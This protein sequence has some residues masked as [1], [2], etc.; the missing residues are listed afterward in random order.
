MM[1]WRRP[2]DKP[3]FETMMVSLLKHTCVTHPQWAHEA[4]QD[5]VD[6][7]E[8]ANKFK[9][10]GPQMTNV[11]RELQRK[12]MQ[13]CSQPANGLSNLGFRIFTTQWQTSFGTVHIR[14]WVPFGA[15]RVEWRPY[16]R[17]PENSLMMPVT[18][19]GTLITKY[20]KEVNKGVHLFRGVELVLQVWGWVEYLVPFF[21]NFNEPKYSWD[22]FPVCILFS[23]LVVVSSVFMASV[24]VHKNV[25]WQFLSQAN[26]H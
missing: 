6:H 23:G 13:L 15:G 5:I 10:T 17:L 1:G 3:L 25:Y 4:P 22:R 9:H 2:G 20:F 26:K 18:F 8:W 21:E 19:N 16:Q 12:H 11:Q 14:V 24:Y 7:F